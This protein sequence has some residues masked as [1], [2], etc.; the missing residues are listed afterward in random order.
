MI[1][2]D[3]DVL[4]EL[5][6]PEPSARVLSWVDQHPRDQLYIA[7]ITVS[8][9]VLEL[10]DRPAGRRRAMAAAALADVVDI[11]FGDRI[12]PFDSRA[13][14][15][16]ARL[17]DGVDSA[18]SGRRADRAMVAATAVSA[19]AAVL[20]SGRAAGLGELITLDVVDPWAA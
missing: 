18:R 10:A 13:S 17:L 1:V 12:L 2:L 16:Y 20:A 8:A 11:D 9:L 3:T 5:T 14:V 15:E 19:G 6:R 4:S 7:S